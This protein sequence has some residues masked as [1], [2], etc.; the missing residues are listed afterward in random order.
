MLKLKLFSPFDQSLTEMF[1]TLLGDIV[2]VVGNKGVHSEDE[3]IGDMRLY[4]PDLLLVGVGIPN[5][6][7]NVINAG[8]K[9][10]AIVCS[11]TGVDFVDLGAATQ[12]GIFVTNVPDFALVAAAEY[13]LG[14]MFATNRK[15]VSA[16]LAATSGNWNKREEFEGTE[17]QGK[18]LGILG[19][20]RI[21][22]HLA[23]IA[24]GIGMN[25]IAYDPYVTADV[26]RELEIPLIDLDTLLKDSDV[27]SIHVPLI[28]STRKMIAEK[29]LRAMKKSAFIV[30]C[31][32]GSVID[33]KALTKALKE[34]WIAGAALDVLE[35]EPPSRDNPLLSLD[36]VVVTPH[37]AWNTREATEKSQKAIREEITRIIKGEMPRN[38]VNR[39][40]LHRLNSVSGK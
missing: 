17:L 39:E 20:G 36:N 11:S 21:G 16:H 30:N 7:M 31:A 25:V 26:G 3:F 40:V 6:T 29:Q 12:K 23:L 18:T 13:A 10:R 5:I 1:R 28:D 32:R 19:I 24:K 35:E 4:D 37:I 33:E 8:K 14:L 9:L 22:R 2:D 27:V 38:L 15:I 34:R